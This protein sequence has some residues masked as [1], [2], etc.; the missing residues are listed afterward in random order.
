MKDE[1]AIV[2][3][4]GE[5][6]ATDAQHA[7]IKVLDKQRSDVGVNWAYCESCG[8]AVSSRCARKRTRKGRQVLCRMCARRRRA[9]R[10]NDSD[11]FVYL[12]AVCRAPIPRSG[13]AKARYAA[14]CGNECDCGEI[15]CKIEHA[16][17]RK[18]RRM[19]DIERARKKWS[20]ANKIKNDGK[21]CQDCGAAYVRG[22]SKGRCNKC[23]CK[24]RY[25]G[26]SPYCG[27]AQCRLVG[28]DVVRKRAQARGMAPLPCSVCKGPSTIDSSNHVRR[29]ARMGKIYNPYCA[30]C[31]PRKKA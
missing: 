13:L 28:K 27:S 15:A 3:S 26:A 25:R 11:T 18:M 1:T 21:T 16:L 19:E 29:Y 10:A 17:R 14:K 9:D 22:F 5:L 4:L 24:H 20:E 6:A 23:A 2:F 8:A 30:S 12:C 7:A 31:S